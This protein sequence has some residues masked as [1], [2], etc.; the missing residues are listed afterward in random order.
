MLTAK[1]IRLAPITAA[2]ASACIRRLHY[3]GKIVQ[4][5]QLHLGVFIA[6]RLEGAMQFGPSLDKRKL[7]GLVQDTPW[8]GFIE[9]NRLA[10]SARLPRN[11]ES[12][13]LGVALRLI[14]KTY[15]HLQWIVSFA[16][17]AQSGDGAIY[18]A[19]GF[20]LT[21]IKRNT[22]IW[23]APGG[24]RFSDHAM[25]NVDHHTRQYAAAQRIVSRTTVTKGPYVANA[26]GAAS[27]RA[28]RAAGFAPIDG[29]QLRYLYFLDPTARQRM[30]VPIL[31]FDAINRVGAG[32]YLGQKRVKQA[33]DAHHAPGGGAAPTHTLQLTEAA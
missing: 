32:M 8:N 3:S 19:S 10:L 17:A 29:Y 31:P 26:G 20:V 25:R 23:Q 7:R 11:S 2:D 27:M 5:S 15:P 33:T 30:T 12:R 24:A 13:A 1:D 18:R 14:R 6:D 21:G 22:S 16:D 28:Y 4:N 9:L